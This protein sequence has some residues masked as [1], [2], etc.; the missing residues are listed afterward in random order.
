MPPP[1]LG[2]SVTGET[3]RSSVFLFFLFFYAE[4]WDAGC[5]R[6]RAGPGRPPVGARRRGHAPRCFAGARTARTPAADPT[7][8]RNAPPP[9]VARRGALDP[10]HT[11]GPRPPPERCGAVAAAARPSAWSNGLVRTLALLV[12]ELVRPSGHFT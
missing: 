1:Y 2:G 4:A 9:T 7:V 6:G 12:R 5:L 8:R 10:R 11:T 3:A